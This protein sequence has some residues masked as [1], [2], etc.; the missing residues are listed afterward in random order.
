[1]MIEITIWHRA[2]F[3]F[4]YSFS[5]NS[6][7]R[8]FFCNLNRCDRKYCVLWLIN[9]LLLLCGDKLLMTKLCF[10]NKNHRKI[11]LMTN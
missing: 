6:A 8:D 3:N 4:Y 11:K 1:M 9:L 5:K 10:T 2:I 7:A